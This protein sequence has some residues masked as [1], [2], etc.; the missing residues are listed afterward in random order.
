MNLPRLSE[1]TKNRLG[2]LVA[3]I[4]VAP[5]IFLGNQ[6]WMFVHAVWAEHW[7]RKD[8]APVTAIVTHVDRKSFLDY[9]YTM[10]G[11][12]YTGNDRRDWEDEKNHPSAV[13]DRITA[14]V[15][16][17]HPW[18][19]RIDL[20]GTAWIGLPIALLILVFELFMLAVLIA[21]I[22]QLVFGIQLHSGKPEDMLFILVA[23][24]ALA[25]FMVL[26]AFAWLKN[27]RIRVF[28]TRR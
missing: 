5:M 22:L 9:R 23:A 1:R 18:F 15:S 7:V 12:D 25:G 4:V 16:V 28:L 2:G 11:K 24:C 26:A 3:L 20:S 6:V 10:N 13:G 8:A 27:R 19:S 14:Y 17:S 21:G